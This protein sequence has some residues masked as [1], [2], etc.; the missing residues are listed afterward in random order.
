MDFSNI[1]LGIPPPNAGRRGSDP[2][3]PGH[4]SYS[5]DTGTGAGAGPA[6]GGVINMGHASAAGGSSLYPNTEFSFPQQDPLRGFL[7]TPYTKPEISLQNYVSSSAL[8]SVKHDLKL[9]EAQLQESPGKYETSDLWDLQLTLSHIS[10][11]IGSAINLRSDYPIPDT[12]VPVQQQPRQPPKLP[13]TTTKSSLSE[14]FACRLCERRNKR[15][16]LGSRST[17]SRH[18]ADVHGGRTKHRCH[19]PGC[20]VVRFRADKIKKHRDVHS[21]R[22]PEFN[23]LREPECYLETQMPPPKK[24]PICNRAVGTWDEWMACVAA[25]CRCSDGISS[26]DMGGF[27]DDGDDDNGGNGSG[28][29]NGGGGNGYGDYDQSPAYQNGL[30]A[31]T[32]SLFGA[33]GTY[34]FSTGGYNGFAKG[35]RQTTPCGP[36]TAPSDIRAPSVATSECETLADTSEDPKSVMQKGNLNLDKSS[37]VSPGSSEDKPKAQRVTF[38]F[39]FPTKLNAKEGY[40]RSETLR[41]P[42]MPRKKLVQTVLKCCLPPSNDS[43]TACKPQNKEILSSKPN[44]LM[45]KNCLSWKS[46]VPMGETRSPR[47][48]SLEHAAPSAEH[49]RYPATPQSNSGLS[50]WQTGREFWVF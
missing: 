10:C 35:C 33:E 37:P 26:D 21:K 38:A 3:P 41:K 50:K 46:I 47:L 45:R 13:S 48:I 2:G 40:L 11:K 17:F 43:T 15:S 27:G 29:G 49:K 6:T 30:I 34:N 36:K 42:P 12:T 16:I 31:G 18:I 20:T 19:V 32:G 25:H 7:L 23:S 14:R 44:T 5:T 8:D 1:H 9:F 28:N 4:N 39:P 22:N 24:C